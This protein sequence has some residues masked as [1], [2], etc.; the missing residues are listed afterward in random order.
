MSLLRRQ[1][2]SR[3]FPSH[4]DQPKRLLGIWLSLSCLLML[5][6]ANAQALS[7][8]VKLTG[9]EGRYLSNVEALLAIYQERGDKEMSV[10]RLRALYR[11]AP[12]Q[13]RE[14]LAPFGLYRVEI[15]SSLTEPSADDGTWTAAFKVNPGDPV[16]IGQ[17]DYRVTGAGADNPR[18]PKQFPMKIGDPLI[19]SDY[20]KAKS[21]ILNIAS[22][23]GY[24][25]ANLVRHLVL[26]DPVAYEAIV[27]FHLET[28]E[29]FYLGRVRFK[30][31]LLKDAFLEK[32]VNFKPG[33]IYNPELL[34]GLQG[35]LIGTEY[36]SEV[37][38][39]PLRDQI[40]P[41]RQVPIEVIATRNKA[42]VYRVGIGY[43]TDVGP[44]FNLDYRRRYI[45][46]SG[47]NLRAEIEVSQIEQSLVGE[48]RIPIRNPVQDYLLIR[49]EYYAFDTDSREGDLFKLSVAQSVLTKHGWRRILG[50]DYRY[51]DFS[52]ATEDDGNFNGLVPNISWSKVV[53][54]DPINT[55][56]GYK[57]NAYFQGTSEDLL[58]TNN[59]L[60][61][62]LNYKLIKSL[63]EKMRFI[64]RTNL[65]AIWAANV[66]DVPASQRFFA[67][68]DNS[69]RGWA[70]DVLGPDDPLN[71]ET[72]GGRF[73]AVGSLEL[74]HQIVGNWGG[75]V[76]TDFGNAFDPDYPEKWEQSV[77]LGIR[78]STPIGPV[79]LDL[80]YALT[81]DPAGFR[82]HFALGPDL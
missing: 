70:F 41:D 38:I 24:I 48:Y 23:E 45:G 1:D 67:G 57:I 55:R 73:L 3:L 11:Q 44:R 79:R 21:R 49:P 64:G 82:L 22:E 35:R 36:F 30:Q 34:L 28:G 52:V 40:G 16:K 12:E 13:I 42:N 63:G 26:I 4:R 7:L 72:V 47:H 17:I 61:A 33:V 20:E 29:Q 2:R 51:E 9:L 18:F 46:R 5:L 59:W 66:D 37:E 60:S 10:P 68:G 69:I 78:Y 15:E 53:A 62:Q 65:G 81:K 31:D 76:F 8:E 27:E 39:Q 75:A 25:N 77:G 32:F 19:H 6:P 54:D 74:E 50:V 80:A 56:N 58:S 71:N 43:G 14:A